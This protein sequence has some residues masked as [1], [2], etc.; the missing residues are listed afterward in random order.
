MTDPL[1]C[2]SDSFGWAERRL[3]LARSRCVRTVSRCTPKVRASAAIEL[4]ARYWATRSRASSGCRIRFGVTTAGLS[5]R[6][7]RFAPPLVRLVTSRDVAAVGCERCRSRCT[8]LICFEPPSKDTHLHAS[9]AQLDRA[10]VSGTEGRGFKS[11][12]MHHM[13]RNAKIF[14]IPLTPLPYHQLIK[15]PHCRML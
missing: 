13:F 9:V 14:Y 4:P 6:G 12:R 5:G 2:S 1:T 8:K 3:T 10:S 7:D 15:V 11:L